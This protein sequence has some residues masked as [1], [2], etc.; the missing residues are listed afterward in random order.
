MIPILNPLIKKLG[1]MLQ[2]QCAGSVLTTNTWT[3]SQKGG[4]NDHFYT[5]IDSTSNMK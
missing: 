2:E 3:G 4:I 1:A 5:Q